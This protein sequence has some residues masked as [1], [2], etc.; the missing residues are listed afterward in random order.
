MY[1]R[2]KCPYSYFLLALEFYFTVL[3]SLQGFGREKD[4]NRGK[5]IGSNLVI[6]CYKELDKFGLCKSVS[7]SEVIFIVYSEPI[8]NGQ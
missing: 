7:Q 4:D 8:E 2:P 5:F 1:Q 3:F 6:F